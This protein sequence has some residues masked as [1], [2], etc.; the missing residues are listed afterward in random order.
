MRYPRE[1]LDAY[2]KGAGELENELIDEYNAGPSRARELLRRG[3]VLG[4]S[5]PLLEPHRRRAARGRGTAA[6]AAPTAGT[7]RVGS[8]AA[9]GS[10][11][12]PLLQSL[13]ALGRLAHRGRAA[14]LRRQELAARAAARD[15][16]EGV[17]QGEDVDVQDPPERQVPRRHAADAPTTSSRPSS[18][19]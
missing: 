5:L 18:G 6:S 7:L 14:R 8:P 3:S 12:P 19:C 10:L 2:R 1:E 17:E 13:G 4:M 16:V 11:E 15:L 9:D